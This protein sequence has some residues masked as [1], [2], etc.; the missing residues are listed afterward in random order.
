[1]IGGID[2]T[3]D[4]A[5]SGTDFQSIYDPKSQAIINAVRV[6][7]DPIGLTDPPSSPAV[8]NLTLQDKIVNQ[9]RGVYGKYGVPYYDLYG[10]KTV[11][12]VT[13]GYTVIF[14]TGLYGSD[15]IHLAKVGHKRLKA[16]QMGTLLKRLWAAA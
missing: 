3:N 11:E 14:P 6:T 1:M 13:S 16:N 8:Y 4:M 9:A 5:G 12:G 2:Q 10:W 15:T 7:A